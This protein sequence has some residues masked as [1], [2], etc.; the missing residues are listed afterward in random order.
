[1]NNWCLENWPIV[2]TSTIAFKGIS[3]LVIPEWEGGH[4][5]RSLIILKKSRWHMYAAAVC[6]H[7]HPL[8]TSILTKLYGVFWMI[9][10]DIKCLPSCLHLVKLMVSLEWLGNVSG[11]L[12]CINVTLLKIASKNEKER[13]NVFFLKTMFMRSNICGVCGWPHLLMYL[14]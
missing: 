4:F 12:W 5:V 6:R 14:L 3:T 9:N 8:L 1:M 13:K 2:Q 7:T 10:I 11:M